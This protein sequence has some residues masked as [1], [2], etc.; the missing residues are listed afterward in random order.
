MSQYI[1]RPLADVVKSTHQK[2]AI[3]EGA[4]AVGKSLTAQTELA[5]NVY[6]YYSLSDNATYEEATHNIDGWVKSL[7]EY[8]IIDEAQRI[9]KLPM[10]IKNI[11]DKKDTE[12]PQF[13]LTGSAA[14]TRNGLD[15]QDP[16]TRRS[17]RFR[18]YPF[19]RREYLKNTQK[20]IVDLLWDETPNEEYNG[21]T[22]DTELQRYIT[23]GGFPTYLLNSSLMTEMERKQSV[24]E[25]LANVI[26][27]TTINDDR[28]DTVCA[29]SMLQELLTTPGGILNQQKLA[30]QL[31]I[32]HRTVTR[33]LSIFENRFLVSALPNLRLAANKQTFSRVKIHPVDTSFSVNA[34]T[35]AGKDFTKDRVLFGEVLEAFVTNQIIPEIQW[36]THMPEVFYW[37]ETGQH[38]KEVD[39]VLVSGNE[40]I[41]IEVKANSTV[42]RDDFAGLVQLEK[43]DSRFKRG[44]VLYT[45]KKVIKRSQKYWAIPISALWNSDGFL[46]ESKTG[47]PLIE[48][49]S[50]LNTRTAPIK[51]KT[52]MSP[53]VSSAP[54]DANIFLSYSH[55]DNS[56]LNGKILSLADDLVTAY[57]YISGHTLNLFTDAN[58]IDWGDD[59]KKAIDSNIGIANI[60]IPI[61]SPNYLNSTNCRSELIA[62]NS[63][64]NAKTDNK[65]LTLKLQNYD[66]L[67]DN[68]N[69]IS[70]IVDQYQWL[71]IEQ[72]PDLLPQTVEYNKLTRTLASKL[73]TVIQKQNNRSQQ[74]SPTIHDNVRKK[75]ADTVTSPEEPDLITLFQEAS[76]ELPKFTDYGTRTETVFASL[77]QHINQQPF[78]SDATPAQMQIW[79]GDI[80][81]AVR[82]DVS[83]LETLISDIN[84]SWNKIYRTLANSC[85][86]IATMPA[87]E[88]RSTR[89]ASLTD[90][91]DEIKQGTTLPEE[92]QQMVSMIPMLGNIFHPLQPLST[93]LLRL[94]TLIG[95]IRKMCDT[96]L[97]QLD[98]LS[99]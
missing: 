8:A 87:G 70:Q 13:I 81:L 80:A 45:G 77:S 78:P 79:C 73:Q 55:K 24:R 20:S 67:R 66:N 93:A 49:L 36:S 96:L 51:T 61:I 98:A 65:I 12:I 56:F 27:D 60:I 2:V 62:F 64:V 99:R 91:L 6:H 94:I 7:P 22:T 95:D 48:T 14:I 63:R 90:A 18:L 43:S 47:N 92:T 9:N 37:R 54:V 86:F 76:E 40:L 35:R 17:R 3:L 74:A 30:E 1:H 58:S 4:R 38:P 34:L 46:N 84:A 85:Q 71:S 72:L 41:G 50:S 19:T 16:L 82:D 32:D 89:I 59:W 88:I 28:F 11:V 52:K 21:N 26:G 75:K 23:V 15:G 31:K 68:E 97:E 42:Q 33:Y 29:L 69:P 10:A 39:L 5:D 53:S 25:D 44:F 83:N 57:E